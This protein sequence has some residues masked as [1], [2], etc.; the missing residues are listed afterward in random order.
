LVCRNLT[1]LNKDFA[2]TRYRAVV[3]T[4][5]HANVGL[6]FTIKKP[7]PPVSKVGTVGLQFLP[8]TV[9]TVSGSRGL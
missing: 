3:L 5:F 4:S 1:T 9:L 6:T 8:S 2:P 7:F